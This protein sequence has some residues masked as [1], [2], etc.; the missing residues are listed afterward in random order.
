MPK[1]STYL[2]RYHL[3]DQAG[4]FDTNPANTFAKAED[5]SALYRGPVEYPK[6]LYHPEGKT[7]VMVQATAVDTPFGPQLRGEQR[8]IIHQIVLNEEDE[9][10]MLEQG[11][12]ETPSAA[13]RAG[14]GIAPETP[15]EEAKRLQKETVSQA[16]E[17]ARLK[18]MLAENGVDLDAAK[19]LMAKTAK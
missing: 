1:A 11:W 5:G 2:T 17:I 3:M 12:H 8:A 4:Y 10:L 19:P 7:K 16:D 6:M 13:V 18:A 15:L 14:G 9:K